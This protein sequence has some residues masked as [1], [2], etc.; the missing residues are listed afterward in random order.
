M[1]CVEIPGCIA[2]SPD[3]DYSVFPY[4]VTVHPASGAF[5]CLVDHTFFCLNGDSSAL[6]RGRRS[7]G[8]TMKPLVKIFRLKSWGR[9]NGIPFSDPNLTNFHGPRLNYDVGKSSSR[10]AQVLKKGPLL[11]SAYDFIYTL[12]T[13]PISLPRIQHRVPRNSPRRSQ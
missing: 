11:G 4:S 1:Y 9:P 3:A 2:A 12:S 5:Y 6:T 7:L 10:Y 8:S 13:F